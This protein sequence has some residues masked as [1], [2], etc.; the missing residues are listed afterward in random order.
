VWRKEHQQRIKELNLVSNGEV[1]Y[2]SKRNKYQ[3]FFGK[4]AP[5]RV[6]IERQNPLVFF[7][8]KNA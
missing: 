1:F 6:L 8:K 3:H 2:V 7:L 5:L 4:N